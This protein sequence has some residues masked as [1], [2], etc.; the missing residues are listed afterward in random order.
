MKTL[1]E[2]IKDVLQS[3]TSKAQKTIDL[4]KLGI[5]KNEIQNLFKVY[6]L[7]DEKTIPYTLGVEIECYN[8]DRDEFIEKARE[9]YIEIVCEN[10]NH[11]TRNYYKAV[12]DASIKVIMLCPDL[13]VIFFR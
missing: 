1:N 11:D 3:K 7:D 9:K 2:Q 5:R 4:I 10:Y 6:Q 12:R 13:E 8:V